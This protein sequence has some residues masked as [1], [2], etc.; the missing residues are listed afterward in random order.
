[1]SACGILQT[2]LY[3][4]EFESRHLNNMNVSDYLT[5][6]QMEIS[7]TWGTEVEV[8]ALVTLLK[9]TIAIYY[10]PPG[11][12]APLWHHYSPLCSD[13]DTSICIY[14]HNTGNHFNCVKTCNFHFMQS[15]CTTSVFFL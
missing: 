12:K 13:A 9:T 8:I 3:Q 7:G 2:D 4:S 11:A 14:L 5:T 15:V 6:T 1:M 10:H